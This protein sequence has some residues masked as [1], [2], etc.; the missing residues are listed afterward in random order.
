MR[1]LSITDDPLITQLSGGKS[2]RFSDALGTRPGGA[3]IDLWWDWTRSIGVLATQSPGAR[4]WKI[5][6]CQSSMMDSPGRCV[7]G[8]VFHAQRSSGP[9]WEGCLEVTNQFSRPRTILIS[10]PTPGWAEER[11]ESGRLNFAVRIAS[12]RFENVISLVSHVDPDT[13][14]N[15]L[16]VN[17]T[18]VPCTIPPSIRSPVHPINTIIPRAH[19]DIGLQSPEG[20]N[21]RD[22]IR[23]EFAVTITIT[24]GSV[25][26]NALRN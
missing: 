25:C 14:R 23:T 1:P 19:V 26:D 6:I 9:P 20:D 8:P 7:S 4:P 10:S 24:A 2:W 18:N 22:T 3:L 12:T 11:A 5:R 16:L 21:C 17:W 13:K 15:Q